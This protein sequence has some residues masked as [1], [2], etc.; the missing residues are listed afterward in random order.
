[1]KDWIRHWCSDKYGTLEK[2]GSVLSDCGYRVGI[3]TIA[4]CRELVTCKKCLKIMQ[5]EQGK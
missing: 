5:K 1:M 3:G 2:D 4:S